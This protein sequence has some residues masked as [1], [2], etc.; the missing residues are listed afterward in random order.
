MSRDLS[1]VTQRRSRRIVATLLML[2]AALGTGVFL[3]TAKVPPPAEAGDVTRVQPDPGERDFEGGVIVFNLEYEDDL[4]PAVPWG[5]EHA[6]VQR[7]GNV[8]YLTGVEPGASGRDAA[9]HW[10]PLADV[11]RISE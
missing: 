1:A 9:R 2:V 6:R 7:L 3:A 4:V 11:V 5:F 10:V 8:Y